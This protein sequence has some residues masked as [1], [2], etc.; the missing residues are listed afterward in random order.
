LSSLLFKRFS[1]RGFRL[2]ALKTVGR[3]GRIKVRE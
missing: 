2:L 3:V 1:G